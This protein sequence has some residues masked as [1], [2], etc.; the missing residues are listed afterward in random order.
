MDCEVDEIIMYNTI[1]KTILHAV[2][3]NKRDQKSTMLAYSDGLAA[4]LLFGLLWSAA[5]L[6][7]CVA[8]GNIIPMH[9]KN[10]ED[11]EIANVTMYP[12]R[13]G[14]NDLHLR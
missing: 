13:H 1:I 2:E 5:S 14:L 11:E 4:Q 9:P 12:Y 7:M 6:E 10:I 8:K 3:I